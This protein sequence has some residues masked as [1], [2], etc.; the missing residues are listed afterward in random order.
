M[1][2]AAEMWQQILTWFP[3]V[4][5]LPLFAAAI[6]WTYTFGFTD[7][8]AH[9][10]AS[11]LT[12]AA[13]ALVYGACLAVGNR[14]AVL[15]S[16]PLALL[17]G[18]AA[19]YLQVSGGFFDGFLALGAIVSLAYAAALVWTLCEKRRRARGVTLSAGHSTESSS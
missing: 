1:Y 6:T 19:I 15:S 10:R 7:F 13:L 9:L 11:M 8:R 5:S 12:M 3:R 2:R 17:V 14:L 16:I 4:A 18:G